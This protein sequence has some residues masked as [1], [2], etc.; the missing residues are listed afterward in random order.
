M[1][2]VASKWLSFLRFAY[3]RGLQAVLESYYNILKLLLQAM[4]SSSNVALQVISEDRNLN[5]TRTGNIGR[6]W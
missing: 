5:S 6:V 1:A 3:C 2:D 4:A